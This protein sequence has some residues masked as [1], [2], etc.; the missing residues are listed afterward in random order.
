ME[1]TMIAAGP[2]E[3]SVGLHDGRPLFGNTS[4]KQAGTHWYVFM[5]PNT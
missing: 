2:L 5:K 3:A 4:G 1:E